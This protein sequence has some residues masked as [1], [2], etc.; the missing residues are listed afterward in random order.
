MLA[1]RAA[2]T[3]IRV[4]CGRQFQKS[5]RESAK[6]ALETAIRRL[7]L[8]DKFQIA[9]QTIRCPETGSSFSFHGLERNREEIR[10]LE[11]IDIAWIEEAQYLSTETARILI[12][13]MFRRPHSEMWFSWNPENRTD[14]IYQ[15]FVLY[16]EENDVSVLVNYHDNGYWWQTCA[17]CGERRKIAEEHCQKCDTRYREDSTP[18]EWESWFPAGLE[19]ERA[20][21]ERLNPD[22]YRWIWLGEPADEGVEQLVLPYAL[23]RRCVDAYTR[24][25]DVDKGWVQAGLDIA[26][27]G[28]AHNAFVVRRGPVIS[29]AER[30][31]GKSSQTV[32]HVH[33]LACDQGVADIYYDSGGVGA[34]ARLFFD[35][36]ENERPYL[37]HAENFGSA[38]KGGDRQFDYSMDNQDTFSRRNAQLA[39]GLRMRALA[40]DRL[41]DGDQSVNPELCLF[42]D[43]K[44]PR[45]DVFLGQ[46]AQPKWR[47]SQS[48]KIEVEKAPDDEPSPDLYDA[49]ALAFA[50]DSLSGLVAQHV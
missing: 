4:M 34:F 29:Y 10:G 48:G 16:P 25:I 45:L 1:Q 14:W 43:P 49:A 18:G 44:I 23:V 32:E 2:D 20:R 47:R 36:I 38:V 17:S 33:S 22:V 5:I 37:V 3:E 9:D 6:P 46:L 50:Y 11:G 42:I 39:W 24:H 26:D 30:W 19:A 13:T 35:Q 31:R 8:R 21:D 27:T 40:T 41:M 15:R 28:P 7:G 12:P